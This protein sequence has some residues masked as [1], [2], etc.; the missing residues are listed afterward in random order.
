M[1]QPST[2]AGKST[3][4]PKRLGRGTRIIGRSHAE[5]WAWHPTCENSGW[6]HYWH[7]SADPVRVVRVQNRSQKGAE[8]VGPVSGRKYES[9]PTVTRTLAAVY[10]CK[11]GGT[12]TYLI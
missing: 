7:V 1:G 4:E 9:G 10:F 8:T 5:P 3:A 11:N 6:S 12:L 2:A